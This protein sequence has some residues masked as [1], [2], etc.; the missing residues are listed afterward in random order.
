MSENHS[1][2][3][4]LQRV[5]AGDQEAARELVQSY[6]SAIRR[7]VR[8]RL[9]DSRLARVFDS[10]D[11]CQ[12]VLASFF[13]RAAAGQYDLAE[14]E[15]LVKLL[16]AM[17]RNKLAMQARAQQRQRRDHRR[18]KAD[19][20]DDKLIASA[21]PT[22]SA[23]VSGKELLAEADRLMSPAE[24]E[25]VELRKDGLEWDAIAEKLGGSAEALRKKLT[26]AVDRVAQQLHLDD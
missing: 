3:E 19:G 24:R 13:V 15:Q 9:A 2:Q 17:A 18:V 7:V 1:F 12:S 10:M 16:A 23:I 8:F 26:R 4:L 5:R 21:E 6:E 11:I 20:L 22:P 14:P 25:L